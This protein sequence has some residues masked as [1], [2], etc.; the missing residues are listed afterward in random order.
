MIKA[1]LNGSRPRSSRASWQLLEASISA[2]STSKKEEPILRNLSFDD[3]F[4]HDNNLRPGFGSRFSSPSVLFIPSF[5]GIS[6]LSNEWTFSCKSLWD[7]LPRLMLSR[8]HSHPDFISFYF[9]LLNAS[10]SSL[11]AST[12]VWPLPLP[13]PEILN[14]GPPQ[15]K[16]G[17]RTMHH[18]R[19]LNLLV[20]FLN[21]LHLR[22]PKVASPSLN[23]IRLLSEKQI[24]LVRRLAGASISWNCTKA[25]CSGLGRS[26]QKLSRVA[27]TIQDLSI[28]G[29]QIQSSLD[30]Y[31]HPKGEAQHK[32][33][34][35]F[36]CRDSSTVVG[37]VRM[38]EVVVAQE[39]VASRFTFRK[40][41]QFDFVPFMNEDTAEAYLKPSVLKHGEEMGTL[42]FT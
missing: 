14:K 41:P 19:Y 28:V 1:A 25:Q 4:I 35:Q 10:R 18:R 11:S 24:A 42:P 5:C 23:C 15:S 31:F 34:H 3:S 32:R 39:I 22:R 40:K 17:H 13:H 6:Q 38:R 27:K 2:L 33:K 9:S 7:G 29:L 12:E 30:P 20:T 26:G 36:K 21:W 8:K 16:W 37:Q